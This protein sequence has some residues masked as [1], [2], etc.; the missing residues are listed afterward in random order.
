MKFFIFINS[1]FGDMMLFTHICSL[2]K[3]LHPDCINSFAID[4]KFK[5]QFDNGKEGTDALNELGE[6]F[7]LQNGVDYVGI[8]DKD[9]KQFI[10]KFAKTPELLEKI[11]NEGNNYFVFD[12][13]YTAASHYWSDINLIASMYCRFT[14][15]HGY[16]PYIGETQFNVGT[17]K[18]LPIDNTKRVAIAGPINWKQKWYGKEDEIFI[19]ID[20]IKSKSDIELIEIGPENGNSYL[21]NLR[22][23]NNCH[24][25]IAPMGSLIHC[26]AGLGVNTISLSSIYPPTWDNPEYYHS[27][28]HRGIACLPEKHCGD[29]ACITPKYKYHSMD[30]LKWK[31]PPY[32]EY[33][34][35]W[36]MEC[37]YTNSGKSCIAETTI[38]QLV[39][40][41]EIWY[42]WKSKQ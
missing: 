42:I 6:L 1:G 17:K 30:A 9:T 29:Y 27:G 32:I 33:N 7:I 10:P 14:E 25:L 24:L 18:Q 5:Y 16:H 39:D 8:Y 21:D 15:K 11:I 28:Y 40:A 20:I 2:L 35:P 38:M 22:L 19:L 31:G 13:A 34:T 12:D 36:V 37:P 41:F 23:L 3:S 26:A 4:S